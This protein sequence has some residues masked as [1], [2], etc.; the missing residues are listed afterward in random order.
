MSRPGKSILLSVL[1]IVG[2]LFSGCSTSKS[3][4]VDGNSLALGLFVPNG[5]GV[6]GV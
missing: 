4:Y 3:T 5:S 6:V 2:I 1:A